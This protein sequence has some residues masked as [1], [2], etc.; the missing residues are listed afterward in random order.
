MFD[1]NATDGTLTPTK[2]LTG[3]VNPSALAFS[4]NKKFLYAVNEISNYNGTT[5]GSVTSMSV[6]SATGDL[7]ILNVVSSGGGA[8]PTSLLIR[9]ENGPLPP[10]MA[11]GASRSYL[12]CRMVRSERP[13][14]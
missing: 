3:I 14:T 10:I 11:A 5:T 6:D 8:P 4:P 7:K 12:S 13:R 1:V 2:I 9:R